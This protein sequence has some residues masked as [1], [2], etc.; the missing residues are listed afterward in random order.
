MEQGVFG[1]KSQ[2]QGATR[3]RVL[4]RLRGNE[5]WTCEFLHF[6]AEDPWSPNNSPL[7]SGGCENQ[8]IQIDNS[9]ITTHMLEQLV[10]NMVEMLLHRMRDHRSSH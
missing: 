8:D 4:K 7:G 1:W 3:R 2:E 9:M 6:C 5:S 10:E